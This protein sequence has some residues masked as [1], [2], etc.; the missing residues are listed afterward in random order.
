VALCISDVDGMNMR[1]LFGYEGD[2]T[3]GSIAWL[4]G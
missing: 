1:L 4:A 3:L 2:G